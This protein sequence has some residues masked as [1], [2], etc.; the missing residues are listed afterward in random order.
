MTASTRSVLFLCTGNYYRS[1]FAEILFNH[2]ATT[3]GLPCRA[4]SA[5]L[6]E[7]CWE[8]NVG[9]LSPHTRAALA[10]RGIAHATPRSPR[11][12]T[13][14][15]FESFSRV[16]ALKRAEHLP[17]MEARFAEWAHRI[18]YWAFDD[19]DFQPPHLVLPHIEAAV[20]ELLNSWAQ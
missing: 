20:A 1:R 14:A 6:V 3:R 16:I 10:E 5:G 17:M 8:R 2:L 19:I 4:D 9:P 15:D 18:E 13:A 11:D 7:R 12:V